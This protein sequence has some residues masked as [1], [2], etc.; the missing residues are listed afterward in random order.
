MGTIS[1]EITESGQPVIQD[2]D[3][4]PSNK[5]DIYGFSISLYSGKRVPV[6]KLGNTGSTLE[7]LNLFRAKDVY[8]LQN[9]KDL[10]CHDIEELKERVRLKGIGYETAQLTLDRLANKA[11]DDPTPK[12]CISIERNQIWISPP[13]V[14]DDEA[15]RIYCGSLPLCEIDFRYKS[16]G[17]VIYTRKNRLHVLPKW[18]VYR[19][20]VIKTIQQF[21]T[22]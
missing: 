6:T 19:Q 10:S 8:G 13:E 12:N 11:P 3:G 4:R 2:K 21:E 14:P 20:Q 18:Q 22:Q 15:V 16:R 17:V 9:Y 1:F 7:S 5:E